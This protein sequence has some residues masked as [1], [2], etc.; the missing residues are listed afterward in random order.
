MPGSESPISRLWR[1]HTQ[2]VELLLLGMDNGGLRVAHLVYGIIEGQEKG[3]D[4]G[5]VRRGGLV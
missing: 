3:V 2:I 5:G 1:E 4:S